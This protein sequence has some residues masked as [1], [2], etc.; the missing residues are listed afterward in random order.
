M[1]LGAFLAGLLLAETE[2]HLQVESDIAPF[3]GLLLGLFFMTVGMQISVKL[4]TENFAVIMSGLGLL[5]LG[6]TGLIAVVGKCF[7]LS[8]SAALRTALF[9]APGGEFAFVLF[10]QAAA[11][12]ILEQSLVNRLFLVVALSMALTPLL[13]TVGQALGEKI[14]EVFVSGTTS[15]L[16][17]AAADVDDL[18][19]HVIIAG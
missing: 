7:G 10:G 19:G 15:A 5:L 14:K 13:A 11:A 6:K 8:L 12:G 4:L 1:E 2:Y 3:R 18:K 16:Q 9:L 17:P